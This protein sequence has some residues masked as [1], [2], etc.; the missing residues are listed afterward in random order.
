MGTDE[1]GNTGTAIGAADFCEFDSTISVTGDCFLHMS[2]PYYPGADLL[3]GRGYEGTGNGSVTLGDDV[4]MTY[5]DYSE[6]AHFL[7]SKEDIP[8]AVGGNLN[9]EGTA[10]NTDRFWYN[11]R[12]KIRN[13]DEGA[14]ITVDA[15]RR[16][17]MPL[18][19][20]DAVKE[21]KVTL[22]IQWAGGDDITL[23]PSFDATTDKWS[24]QLTDLAELTKK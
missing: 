15:G 8:E 6:D 9:G 18:L 16:T 7:L 24:F 5:Y 1:N 19:V 21:Y 13:A 23:Q 11:V 2:D 17:F 10:T 14:T 4:G 22:V 3:I 12:N 20:L